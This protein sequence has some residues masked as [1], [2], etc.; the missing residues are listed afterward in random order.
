MQGT[1]RSLILPRLVLLLCA[2][3]GGAPPNVY[4]RAMSDQEAC[5]RGLADEAARQQCL[6]EIVR[7]EQDAERSPTNQQT[8]RC[9]DRHFACDP[10]TGRATKASAQA[11]LDCIQDVQSGGP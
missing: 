1:H 9:V 4:Q 8:F 11:Q 3:C 7:V 2:A 6:A 10:A 5:C